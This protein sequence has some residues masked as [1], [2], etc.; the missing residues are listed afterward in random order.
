MSEA[1]GKHITDSDIKMLD[2][3]C[4][5]SARGNNAEVRK[6]KE[7]Q[8]IIYEVKKKKKMVG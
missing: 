7:G 6:T 4:K 3:A 5:I 8:W 1:N 2:E